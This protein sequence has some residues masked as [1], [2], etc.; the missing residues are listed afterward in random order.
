MIWLFSVVNYHSMM[1]F[2]G[3]NDDKN[4]HAFCCLESIYDARCAY[5][6]QS[7]I[8]S[9]ELSMVNPSPEV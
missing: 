6:K 4:N 1:V 3:I 7:S 5:E 2:I 8:L 9:L